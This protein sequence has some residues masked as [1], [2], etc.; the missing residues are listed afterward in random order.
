MNAVIDKQLSQWDFVCK[1]V[2]EEHR[3][4]QGW[5]T[6]RSVD[7]GGDIVEPK[8]LSFNKEIP[9]FLYHD[10][11]MQVGNAKL[12]KP[13]ENGVP[14]EAHL[15]KISESGNLQDMVNEAWQRVKYN[16]IK[17]VSIGF[18]P[19]FDKVEAIKGGG[20][21]YLE[22]EIL[23][24][25]LVPVPMNAEAAITYIKSIDQSVLAALGTEDPTKSKPLASLPGASGRK[26][27]SLSIIPR[28]IM[29]NAERL[30]GLEAKRAANV[31]RMAELDKQSTDEGRTFNQEEQDEF[32]TLDSE[33]KG[34][35][36]QIVRVRRMLEIVKAQTIQ[37]VPNDT[38]ITMPANVPAGQPVPIRQN[39]GIQFVKSNL[40]PGQTMGRYAMALYRARG[41]LTDA[42]SI[43]TNNKSWMDTSPEV[44]TVL[45][46]AVAAGDTTTAGWASE[47][48]YA[49][50]LANQF[51]E[52]LR[53]KTILGRLPGLIPVPFNVRVGSA[54]G[55]T[56]G[57]W[58]GQGAPI[59]VS[60]MTT[61]SASLGIMKAAGIASITQELAMSS[62][63]SAELL[64]R[65]E[66]ARAVQVTVDTQ[67]INP[68]YGGVANVSPASILY[69]VTP[70]TPTGTNYAAMAADIKTLFATA[71]TAELDIEEVVWVMSASTALAL[72]LSL[73]SLGQPQYPGMSVNGG[74]FMGRPVIVSSLANVSGSPQFSEM[75]VAVF[76]S[77]IFLADEGGVTIS[78]SNE[79]SVQLLDN[80]TNTSTGS[81]APT[82]V[83]SMFQTDSLAVRAIRFITWAKARSQAAA[84]IQAAAYV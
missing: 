37:P 84:F 54:T 12:G 29:T 4:I 23:E 52:F 28:Q 53:P 24:L 10:S 82:T 80:P 43:Y 57:Y 16:L 59:P 18:L 81:T 55:G 8:G 56:T 67:F 14:F 45:K 68:N 77:A 49:Q 64:I 41:N 66:L 58:V 35:D 74:T 1:S 44:A 36:D 48:V 51:I 50:N 71:I 39:S 27:V 3:L 31:A 60:K 7:R 38:G 15:P 30:S 78:V 25:S 47:L 40:E 69:G 73:N 70:V 5:A 42:L 61:S 13:T 6:T 9:L 26:S 19:N 46:A 22:A 62:S 20:Y 76:P 65:N 2:D 34:V 17:F 72:S 63:P 11:R 21:R 83:V 75:I 33:V 32:D 79:A